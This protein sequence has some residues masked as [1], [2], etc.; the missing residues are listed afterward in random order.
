MCQYASQ[1]IL[2]TSEDGKSQI[3][4]RAKNGLAQQTLNR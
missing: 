2:Y 1:F 4:L 3:L